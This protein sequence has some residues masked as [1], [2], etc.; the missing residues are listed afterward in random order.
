VPE[1]PDSQTFAA[2]PVETAGGA[3]EM[4][5]ITPSSGSG[6]AEFAHSGTRSPEALAQSARAEESSLQ[7]QST[8]Q[9]SRIEMVRRQ[10]SPRSFWPDRSR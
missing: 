8:K 10:L 5:A 6:I 3:L 7:R 2:D 4:S 1:V 9:L